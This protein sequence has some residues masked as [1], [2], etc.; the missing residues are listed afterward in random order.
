[1]SET[2]TIPYK[3]RDWAKEFHKSDKRWKVLVLHRRAGKTVACVNHLIRDA[4]TT[5]NSRFA[6]IAPYFKQAKQ[7]AWD[8]LKQYS[9][10]IP[11]L[12]VN[13]SE[14]KIDYPNGARIQLYG[15]DNPDA[16]RG[17]GLWGV[18]FDE[19]SQQ[20][21]SIFT[22]VIRPALSDHQGY[23]IWIGTPKGRNDF[24]RIYTQ[25][26]LPDEEWDKI[27]DAE[28]DRLSN[29]WYRRMLKAS[30]SEVLGP[31]ELEDARRLM[32]ADEYA[33]E[34]ECSFSAAIKGAYYSH[35]L[36]EARREERITKVPYDATVRVNTYWDLGMSDTTCIVFAQTVGREVHIIDFHENNGKGLDF[37]VKL[38]DQ[39]NYNYGHHWLPHDAQARELGTGRSRYEILRG[40]LQGDV[41]VAPKL[42]L[43]DGIEAARM[44]FNRCYF[45]KLQT[46][47][48]IDALGS[49]TQRWN[50]S[51]GM[52]EDRPEHNWA[53]HPADAFRI[54]A[55]AYKEQGV[56]HSHVIPNRYSAE[57]H[58]P[59]KQRT[60]HQLMKKFR[61]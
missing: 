15:A 33:Q 13:E 7:V 42:P 57:T 58:K 21:A 18:V 19:Y 51:K 31:E 28:K 6:Y 59:K 26:G 32:S 9:K 52:F 5:P 39:K 27:S 53:S 43:K 11:G 22:E 40:L 56:S 2:I 17:L 47:P 12:K 20:P 8:I 61:L 10:P 1:M 49:Y 34:Y 60:M 36:A 41:R 23:A 46:A 25:F 4:I 50:D 44:I 14:L 37:Y 35:E 48:L 45:N 38:L 30:E 54:M 29:R 55:T 16:L 24:Y 3:P